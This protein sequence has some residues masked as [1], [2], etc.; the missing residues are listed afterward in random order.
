M[1]EQYSL[2]M[3]GAV[4]SGRGALERIR[5]IAEGRFKK[6]AV[7]TDRGVEQAGLLAV[8][9]EQLRAA[10]AETVVITDLPAEPSCDEAQDIIDRFRETGADLIVAV[11]GGSV[12]D[13]AKL[14]SI[15]AGDSVTV[16]FGPQTS[17]RVGGAIV[18]TAE[19][20]E[21]PGSLPPDPPMEVVPY[22]QPGGA[23][24]SGD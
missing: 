19:S 7:F 22:D 20:V 11:G 23:G 2:S 10:G 13:V 21:G 14:A 5:E 15:G 8:P 3:P 16:R 12:M 6:A 1:L 18:Y 24:I 9:M 4:Y 17:Q